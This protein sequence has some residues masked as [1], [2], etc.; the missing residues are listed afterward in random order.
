MAARVTEPQQDQDMVRGR[1]LLLVAC[2]LSL[3][4]EQRFCSG[5]LLH[6]PL[7]IRER[8]HLDLALETGGGR[9]PSSSRARGLQPGK[10]FSEKILWRMNPASGGHVP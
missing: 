10:T 7:W 8:A 3:S 9:V 4:I 5:C 1:A 6:S 2:L